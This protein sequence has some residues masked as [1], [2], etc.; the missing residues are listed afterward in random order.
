VGSS[1]LPRTHLCSPD[2][3]LLS[4]LHLSLRWLS[5]SHSVLLSYSPCLFFSPN[6]LLLF[7]LLFDRRRGAIKS[8]GSGSGG[9][10]GCDVTYIY[11]QICLVVIEGLS[12]CL[13][14]LVRLAISRLR[15]V[16]AQ[17]MVWIEFAPNFA[18]SEQV[19][20]SI[21]FDRIHIFFRQC[22]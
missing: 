19:V 8:N 15:F 7:V 10:S 5:F 11:C 4:C 12:P 16:R 1:G 21:F 22:R 6:C 13:V 3:L 18:P 2:P 20:Q 9:C 14:P 17:G